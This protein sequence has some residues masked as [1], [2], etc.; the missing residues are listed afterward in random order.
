MFA[1]C[2]TFNQSW[3]PLR[4]THVTETRENSTVVMWPQFRE[5]MEHKCES[6]TSTR[7]LN[8]FHFIH[9]VDL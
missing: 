7:M 3:D 8:H 6:N 4:L 9:L 1:V 2:M 5:F